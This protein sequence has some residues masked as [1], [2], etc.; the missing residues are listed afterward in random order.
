MQPSNHPGQ[1]PAAHDT[2]PL[3][4]TEVSEHEHEVR[5]P[6]PLKYGVPALLD[7]ARNQAG[8]VGPN[9]SLDFGAEQLSFAETTG[10]TYSH[11][12]K[13]PDHRTVLEAIPPAPLAK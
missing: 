9:A 7:Q 4:P 3:T 8:E 11:P 5:N 12:K 10:R 2:K 1:P 6:T 13:K